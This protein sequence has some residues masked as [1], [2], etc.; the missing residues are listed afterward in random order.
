MTKG[1]QRGFKHRIMD[2]AGYQFAGAE[3][4]NFIKILL[5][6]ASLEENDSTWFYHLA[7]LPGEPYVQCEM[8]TAMRNPNSAASLWCCW[9]MWEAKRPPAQCFFFGNHVAMQND[10]SKTRKTM[11]NM[12]KQHSSSTMHNIL[13]LPP[14]N[15]EGITSW[16]T[17][18]CLKRWHALTLSW[19]GRF[20]QLIM[21]QVAG[22]LS[23]SVQLLRCGCHYKCVMLVILPSPTLQVLHLRTRRQMAWEHRRHYEINRFVILWHKRGAWK[24]ALPTNRFTLK[25]SPKVSGLEVSEYQERNR[26]KTYVERLTHMI[27]AKGYVKNVRPARQLWKKEDR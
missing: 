13:P 27:P 12:Q 17:V 4:V 5:K 3:I 15:V 18:N 16:K 26:R 7:G 19:S 25:V 6:T 23:Y 10:N 9:L 21:S 20:F 14:H 8:A 24:A 2:C 11:K 1:W 22:W